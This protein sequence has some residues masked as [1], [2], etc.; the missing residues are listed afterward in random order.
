MAIGPGTLNAVLSLENLTNS[1][2]TLFY[3]V[4]VNGWN[5]L[6]GNSFSLSTFVMSQCKVPPVGYRHQRLM[7]LFLLPRHF[8]LLRQPFTCKVNALPPS[9]F[10]FPLRLRLSLNF[11][12]LVLP[13]SQKCARSSDSIFLSASFQAPPP[14]AI[15]KFVP[16]F[17]FASDFI[18]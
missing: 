16:Y 10:F 2:L 15:F 7:S 6:R 18:S 11:T 1:T 13:S 17:N 4:P 12:I 8:S 5:R 14:S 9:L 3:T